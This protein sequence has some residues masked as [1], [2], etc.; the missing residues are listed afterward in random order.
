VAVSCASGKFPRLGCSHPGGADPQPGASYEAALANIGYEGSLELAG[1]TPVPV[2]DD[3][4]D[5]PYALVHPLPQQTVEL[6]A[7]IA[8]WSGLHGDTPA[9]FQP[10]YADPLGYASMPQST[11]DALAE[12]IGYAA[13]PERTVAYPGISELARGLGLK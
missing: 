5:D 12:P 4:S 6:A 11:Y 2:W 10:G 13:P 1:G 8:D 7:G 3:D 9:W